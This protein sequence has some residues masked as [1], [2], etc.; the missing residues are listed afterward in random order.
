MNS[1]RNA[2]Y[3]TGT[4]K[5]VPVTIGASGMGCPSIDIYSYELYTAYD[6]EC[7]IRIGTAG[8]YDSTT[9]VYDVINVDKAYS[10][11]T[12]AREAFEISADHL[13]HQGIA[14]DLINDTAQ[15]MNMPVIAANIHSSDVFYRS[16]KG[17][18]PVAAQNNCVC[19]EMEAFALFSNAQYLNKMA[20]TILTISDVIPTGESMSADQ[21]QN[22]LDNMTKLALESVVAI[23]NKL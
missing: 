4:Y 20:A 2:F 16:K 18:P 11:S 8:A 23:Y 6:V 22:S 1:T 14:Y 5:G 13:V 19:V 9:K 10:E 17:T 12:Y 15:K 3:F 7:I 21:R